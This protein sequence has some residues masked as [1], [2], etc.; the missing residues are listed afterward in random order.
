MGVRCLKRGRGPEG[1]R[2]RSGSVSRWLDL[3]EPQL[4]RVGRKRKKLEKGTEE[5]IKSK[6]RIEHC[7]KQHISRFE[8]ATKTNRGGRV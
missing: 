8:L 6:H 3:E 5:K 7:E 1:E 2:A 4:P